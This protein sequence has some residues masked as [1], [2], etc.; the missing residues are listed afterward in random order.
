[1]MKKLDKGN[2]ITLDNAKKTIASTAKTN[3]TTKTVKPTAKTETQQANAKTTAELVKQRLDKRTKLET[4][5]KDIDQLGDALNEF[6]KISGYGDVRV[7]ISCGGHNF[8]TTRQD[9]VDASLVAIRQNIEYK[10]ER[11]HTEL[12]GFAF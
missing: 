6:N 1:M 10:L 8:T 2:G 11:A 9:T 3:G 7:Q 12:A 5:Y 4:L